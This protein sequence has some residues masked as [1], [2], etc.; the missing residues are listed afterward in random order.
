VDYAT[1]ALDNY[2]YGGARTDV[3][4]YF[5]LAKCP[6]C[7]SGWAGRY[8]PKNLA[9]GTHLLRVT[10][11]DVSGKT[12]TSDRYFV[13]NGPVPGS[14]SAS[15]SVGSYNVNAYYTGMYDYYCRYY[16]YVGYGWDYASYCYWSTYYA[17]I[18][19]CTGCGRSAPSCQGTA[20]TIWIQPQWRAG[21]GPPG[22]LVL[23]GSASATGSCTSGGVDL[24]WR[25]PGGAWQHVP[26][27]APVGADGIWYNSIENADFYATYET[28]V[29][30]YNGTASFC[31]YDGRNDIVSCP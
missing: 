7:P 22:S 24:Y 15:P 30:Y 6:Y 5:G 3:C 16:E 27:S 8:D 18:G 28:Y 21:F 11:T 2:N 20:R 9:N 10:A 23:A 1:V 26:Y 13:V 29:T 19:G 4:A 12:A 14:C 31:T 17:S 25:V